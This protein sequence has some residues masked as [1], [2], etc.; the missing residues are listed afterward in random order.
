LAKDVINFAL[1]SIYFILWRVK[2]YP[3]DR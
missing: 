1:Q 2:C 3:W